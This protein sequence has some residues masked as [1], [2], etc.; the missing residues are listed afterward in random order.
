MTLHVEMKNKKDQWEEE[1]KDHFIGDLKAGGRG[2][3]VVS[4]T[5]VIVDKQTNRNFDY[6]LQCGPD[7]IALEIFRLVET[8]E[9]II[10]SKS[11]STIANAIAAELRKRGV[12]G[13]TIDTPHTFNVPRLKIPGFVSKTADRLEAALKQNPQT[14]PIAVDGFEITRVDDFPDVSLFTTGPGGAINPT[15]IAHDFIARK[16]PTKNKQ[17]NIANHERVVLIVN[18]AVLVD[19]SNMIEACGLI[20]FSQFGNIDKVY[21]ELPQAGGI[22]LVYDRR[23]YAAFQPDGEP[24][25]RIEPL[26]ISWLANHLYRKE[27]Q[28]FRLVRK[29]TEQQ[30]SLLWLPAHSREQLISLGEDFLK[31]RESEQLYWIVEN[32]KDDPDPSIE[33]AEDDPEGR[34]NDHLRTK[35]GETSRLIRSVRGRLCWLLMQVVAHPRIGDYGHIFEIVERLATEE[36]LYVRL[37]AAVPLIELAK[38]RFAK[39][40]ANTRFM[41]DSLADRIKTLAIRMV[42]ENMAYPAVLEWAAHVM[43]SIRDLDHNTAFRII[44]QLLTIDQSEAAGDISWMM[45][46]FALYRETQFKD[47]GHFKSDDIRSLLK[48]R[49]ANGNGRFRATAAEHFKLILG[50]ND[51]EFDAVVPYLEAMVNGPSDRIVNHHFYETAAKQAAAHPDI[52]GSLIEQSVLGELKSLDSGVR[53]VWHPKGFSEALHAV[54]QAGPEHRERVTRIRKSIEPYKERRRIYDIDDF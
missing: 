36:N 32:L 34:S 42:D 11:W 26:F 31:N 16:L 50:R 3:W 37:H 28:A 24:P 43:V 48:D 2:D 29:I 1:A 7:F 18:W 4:D 38:R 9:E 17:L 20:D 8:R 41:S 23:I 19:R 46:Y 49:L 21:F 47:L 39:V 15:G 54:E 12:K 5:D 45:I 27:P 14:D 10:R 52:V 25:K 6:Q 13:Y 22:H 53:E 44:K 35:Q 51:I 40:D 30:K 33:N